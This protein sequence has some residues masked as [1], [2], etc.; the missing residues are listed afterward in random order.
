ML[1]HATRAKTAPLE[2]PG[3]QQEYTKRSGCVLDPCWETAGREMPQERTPCGS[4]WMRTRRR[5]PLGSPI[6]SPIPRGFRLREK[7]K[8]ASCMPFGHRCA[9]HHLSI[10]EARPAGRER[11]TLAFSSSNGCS[12]PDRIR[13]PTAGSQ[14]GRRRRRHGQHLGVSCCRRCC[15]FGVPRGWCVPTGSVVP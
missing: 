15:G 10:E 5:F 13:D 6:T 3:S 2:T 14:T 4:S 7:M 9:S 12:R 8:G 1:P 11:P